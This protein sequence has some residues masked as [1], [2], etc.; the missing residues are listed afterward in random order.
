M[1]ISNEVDIVFCYHGLSPLCVVVSYFWKTTALTSQLCGPINASLVSWLRLWLVAVVWAD[2]MINYVAPHTNTSSLCIACQEMCLSKAPVLR[3]QH[4]WV[5]TRVSTSMFRL[6]VH[7]L[8][9]VYAKSEMWWLLL[10]TL[11][12]KLLLWEQPLTKCTHTHSQ[13]SQAVTVWGQIL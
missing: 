2:T 9:A 8:S 1:W 10:Q 6:L 4:V 13:Q 5:C 3:L 7:V 11:G 12:T